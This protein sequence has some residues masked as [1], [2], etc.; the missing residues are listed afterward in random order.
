MRSETAVAASKTDALPSDDE[1]VTAM[2]A[3]HESPKRAIATMPPAIGG[4]LVLNKRQRQ[5]CKAF[6]PEIG[7]CLKRM[8]RNVTRDEPNQREFRSTNGEYENDDEQREAKP[9]PKHDF[10]APD[11]PW[12]DREQQTGLDVA[13][14]GRRRE[15]GR[16][17]GKGNAKHVREHHNEYGDGSGDEC[18]SPVVTDGRSVQLPEAPSGQRDDRDGHEYCGDNDTA[19][20]RFTKGQ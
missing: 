9:L 16:A 19:S 20:R 12:Q 17:Y 8:R 13:C 2:P 18:G 7:Q 10:G 14:E 11:R 5:Q 15:K 6:R 1:T 3:I 4:N